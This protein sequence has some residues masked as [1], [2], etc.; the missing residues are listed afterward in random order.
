MIRTPPANV[1]PYESFGV[2]AAEVEYDVITGERQITQV[3]T[4]FDCGI[5]WETL[6]CWMQVAAAMAQLFE[7]RVSDQKIANSQFDQTTAHASLHFWER[8]FAPI[9]DWGEAVRRSGGPA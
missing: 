6:L 9:F 1:H 8:Y 5:R 3:D 7:R 2:T 4:V